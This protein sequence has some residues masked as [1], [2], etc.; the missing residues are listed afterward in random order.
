VTEDR[1][2]RGWSQDET[3]RVRRHRADGPGTP[4]LSETGTGPI[5]TGPI[6]GPLGTGPITGPLGTERLQ[7][8]RL[9]GDRPRGEGDTGPCPIAAGDAA[10]RRYQGVEHAAHDPAAVATV[11]GRAARAARSCWLPRRHPS[12]IATLGWAD[13]R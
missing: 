5:R 10:A 11:G 3:G 6:A 8:D 7:A 1:A 9:V 12:L 13:R 4:D 2:A